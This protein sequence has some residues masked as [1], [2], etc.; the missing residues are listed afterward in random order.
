MGFESG[1]AYV[2]R[3]PTKSLPEPR[4]TGVTPQLSVLTF[5]RLGNASLSAKYHAD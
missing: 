3:D 4:R 2:T 5:L 1:P